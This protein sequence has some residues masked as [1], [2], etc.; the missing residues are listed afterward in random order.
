MATRRATKTNLLAIPFRQYGTC[1]G[2][3]PPACGPPTISSW[4]FHVP[5][6]VIRSVREC[7]GSMVAACR[8]PPR[9][10]VASP[11]PIACDSVMGACLSGGPRALWPAPSQD[12]LL[13]CLI[14]IYRGCN[15]PPMHTHAPSW[16]TWTNEPLNLTYAMESCQFPPGR[17]RACAPALPGL[18]RAPG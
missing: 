6:T 5:G 8:V 4:L 3:S 1:W 7:T 11:G 10:S 12:A 17:K 18:S 2:C 13:T 14:C 15:V 9:A 16:V